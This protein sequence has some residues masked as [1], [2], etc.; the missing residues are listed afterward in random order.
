MAHERP[1]NGSSNKKWQQEEELFFDI[2]SEH[3]VVVGVL[4]LMTF[5]TPLRVP[6]A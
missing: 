4:L 3:V 1:T 6:L 5:L 2:R